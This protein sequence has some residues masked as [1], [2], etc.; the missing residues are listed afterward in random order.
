MPSIFISYI[1]P[2]YNVRNYLPA[3][4]ESLR[5]QK[6]QAGEEVEFILVNDGSTDDTLSIIKQFAEEDSRV[7][8]LDQENQGVCAARNNGLAIA[9]GE[10]VFFLDGD[11]CL[12]DDASEEIYCFCKDSM[13]D[14]VL[15]SN[16]KLREGQSEGKEWVNPARFCPPGIYSKEE[17][18]E[19]ASYFPISFKL[20]RRAFLASHGI[21]FDQELVAGEVYT[22]YIHSLVLAS[23]V[24]V[25]S[26][27]VMYYL[28]RKGESATTVNNV[29]RDLS[30]LNTLHVVNGYV[31][32]HYPGLME[33]K[34][35]LASSFWLV[36]AFALIKYVGRTPYTK[37]IGRLIRTVKSDGQYRTLLKY[38]TGKGLSASQHSLLAL[39]IRF[40]PSR[41]AYAIIRG[42]YRLAA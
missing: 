31:S 8:V 41:V 27:F 32:E 13:P 17:Y 5:K 12:T 16:Y 42:Y 7:V 25:S 9:K 29:N 11:D 10:Y 3:C 38:L 28:K 18:I 22:F 36:T 30:I 33:K 40:F 37:E 21:R 6:I 15:L 34:A 1:V 23:T 24:G 39:C 20:Y 4:I 2:C 14:V 19:T 26:D 35:Y